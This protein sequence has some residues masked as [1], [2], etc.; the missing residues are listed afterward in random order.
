ME[1]GEEKFQGPFWH[2]AP[3]ARS[4]KCTFPSYRHL[5]RGGF[6]FN[7]VPRP[8]FQQGFHW[9]DMHLWDGKCVSPGNIVHSWVSGLGF[10]F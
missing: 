4:C 2:L 9:Q 1:K 10:S 5:Q 7:L 8:H 3:L 6:I